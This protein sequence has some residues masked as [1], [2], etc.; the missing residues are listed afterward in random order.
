MAQAQAF[1]FDNTTNTKSDGSARYTDPDSRRFSTG[2]NNG[3][4][5]FKQGNTTF[6]FGSQRSL[7]DQ[8][9]YPEQLFSPNGRPGDDR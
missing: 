8:R 2:S 1:T 3:Q 9:Y 5:T 7:T 4:T 6:Q